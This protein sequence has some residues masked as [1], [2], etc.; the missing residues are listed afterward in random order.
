MKEER[1]SRYCSNG[2][3]QAKKPE[4]QLCNSCG[5]HKEKKNDFRDNGAR[6]YSLVCKVCESP[7]C[8]NCGKS[9]PPGKKAFNPTITKLWFCSEM[10]CQLKSQRQRRTKTI[11]QVIRRMPAYFLI[12]CTSTH[13]YILSKDRPLYRKVK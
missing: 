13:A 1:S 10:D 3:C 8:T 9:Y 6:R 4:L 7:S 5:I 2:Q 11:L 12:F